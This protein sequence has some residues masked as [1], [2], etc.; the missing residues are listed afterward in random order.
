M[1]FH[2]INIAPFQ[3]KNSNTKI[4]EKTAMLRLRGTYTGTEKLVLDLDIEMMHISY[5]IKFFCN[6]KPLK[7]IH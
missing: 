6:T 2:N 5:S 3:I 1:I 7:I 4:K